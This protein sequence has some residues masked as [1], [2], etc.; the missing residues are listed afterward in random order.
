VR[1]LILALLLM[2]LSLLGADAA[3][4][5]RAP[6]EMELLMEFIASELLELE[7]LVIQSLPLTREFDRPA[8]GALF[9]RKA[10]SH[11]CTTRSQGRRGTETHLLVVVRLENGSTLPWRAVGATLSAGGEELPGV[12]V[13]HAEPIAQKEAGMILV[14]VK[15]TEEQARGTFTLT[16]RDESGQRLFTLEDVRFP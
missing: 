3:A 6:R 1:R 15:V 13:W 4:K 16:L 12:S 11:R 7:E 9:A 8:G 10:S 2:W 14:K 5:P